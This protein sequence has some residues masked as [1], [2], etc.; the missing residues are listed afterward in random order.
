[1]SCSE[2]YYKNN[3]MSQLTFLRELQTV[4]LLYKLSF[5][6]SLHCLTFFPSLFTATL[7]VRG[8]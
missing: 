3:G 5:S 8:L 4:T 6:L 2:V 1:M 7:N